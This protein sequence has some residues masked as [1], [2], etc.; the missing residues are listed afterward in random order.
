MT[1]PHLF[2]ILALAFAGTTTVEGDAV[3][4]IEEAAEATIRLAGFPDWLEIGFGSVWVSNAGLGAVQRIDAA[5][6]KVIIEVKVNAPCAAMAAGDGSIWVASRK[7]K[8]ICRIDA[9][10]N[11][12]IATIPAALADSEAIIAAGEGGIWA[13][14]DRQGILT[15]IDP[16]TNEVMA[17]IAVKPYSFAAIAGYGSIWVTNTGRPRS[18]ENGSVQ[19]IDPKTNT[20]VATIPVRA[21]PRFL[22][23]GESAIWVLNQADG[24]VSRIDP[25]TNQVVATIAVGVPGP[26][27]DIAA[28]E[29]AVWVRASTV[30]LSV[31]DPKT[32]AVIARFGPPQGSGAVRAGDGHVWVSAHDVNKVWRLNAKAK[33]Q[34]MG[35]ARK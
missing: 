24:S 2:L 15:R 26:G 20:V 7:D 11:R 34:P 4:P 21:Q 1:T 35:R 29:G 23:A 33:S 14:T 18:T 17:R 3:S 9:K 28:G 12:V 6:N 30:L 22:A 27:G 32:N 13:L 10:S 5:T 8:A 31:I 16:T 25:Q 19:R